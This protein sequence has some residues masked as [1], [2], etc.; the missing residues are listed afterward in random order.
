[1]LSLDDKGQPSPSHRLTFQEVERKF[2]RACDFH[3]VAATQRDRARA[4]WSDLFAVSD[5]AQAVQTLATF[6]RPQPL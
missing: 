5:V 2:Q 3:Q 1:L 4:V 6:G